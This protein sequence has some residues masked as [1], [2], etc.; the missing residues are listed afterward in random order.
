VLSIAA[1]LALLLAQ[2]F[3]LQTSVA[4]SGE[5][6]P[7]YG[8]ALFTALIGAIAGTLAA[9]GYSCT[10]GL[11]VSLLVSS[12]LSWALAGVI[13]WVA[14]AA[15]YRRRLT[16]RPG[17]AMLVALLHQVMAS[18]LSGAVYYALQLVG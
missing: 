9:T 5:A 6:A 11:F 16:L 18:A 13:G 17:H 1:I 3:L 15:V 4:L 7:R 12:H 14:T 2:G 8:S 10:A